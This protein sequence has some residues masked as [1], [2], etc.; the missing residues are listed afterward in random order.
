MRLIFVEYYWQVEEISKNKEKFINDIIVS[1][2]HETSYLLMS[3]KIKYFDE[4]F[5]MS[6]ITK[7][8]APIINVELKSGCIR[9][10]NSVKPAIGV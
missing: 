1:L 8:I 10:K 9:I 5:P 3:N 4:D 2:F 7:T 6:N